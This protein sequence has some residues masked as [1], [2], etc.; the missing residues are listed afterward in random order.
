MDKLYGDYDKV[1]E[2]YRN[3]NLYRRRNEKEEFNKVDKKNKMELKKEK[4]NNK[5]D[6]K[7]NKKMKKENGDISDIS[8]NIYT[9]ISYD[10]VD[11]IRKNKKGRKKKR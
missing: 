7:M 6:K 9:D 3:N 8:Q 1:Y 10:Y 4:D 2:K 5:K 11:A